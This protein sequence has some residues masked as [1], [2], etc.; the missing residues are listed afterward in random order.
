VT[1]IC[2]K[3]NISKTAGECYLA[4]IANYYIVCCE[5][6]RSAILATAWLPVYRGSPH[7]AVAR[8]LCFVFD[9]TVFLVQF[10]WSSNIVWFAITS[11]SS[12][13]YIH[14][15]CLC[16]TLL[17]IIHAFDRVLLDAPCSGTGVVSK[18]PAVKSNKVICLFCKLLSRKFFDDESLNAILCVT[19]QNHTG[20]FS[21]VAIQN[22]KCSVLSAC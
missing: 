2:L 22:Y 18:D 21:F 13:F 15:R 14:V 1:P 4:T 6:V 3:P 5:A 9:Q 8:C 7:Y 11:C 12:L 17:Q 19:V 16:F 20:L 10:Q